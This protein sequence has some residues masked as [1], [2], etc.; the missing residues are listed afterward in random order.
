MLPVFTAAQGAYLPSLLLPGERRR[1]R[2]ERDL[3]R[4]REG[5]ERSKRQGGKIFGVG[6]VKKKRGD[7]RGEE[8]GV[9]AGRK[10]GRVKCGEEGAASQDGG[11]GSEEISRGLKEFD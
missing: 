8:M 2:G 10:D 4:E 5:G 6:E 3:Q 1:E 11:K 9:A 7:G